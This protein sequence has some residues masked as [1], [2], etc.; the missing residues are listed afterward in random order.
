MFKKEKGGI[1]ISHGSGVG[2]KEF[3]K[4]D[5]PENLPLA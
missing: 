5:L 1:C 3:G 4:K 2:E